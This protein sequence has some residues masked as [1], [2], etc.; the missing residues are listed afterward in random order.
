MNYLEG[1]IAP[2]FSKELDPSGPR[3]LFGGFYC[4]ITKALRQKGLQQ[5]GFVASLKELNFSNE[6]RDGL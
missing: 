1:D 4:I 5:S 3:V 2:D 6:V